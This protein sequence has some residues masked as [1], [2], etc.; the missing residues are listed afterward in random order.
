M[1]RP[2]RAKASERAARSTNTG[3]NQ[4]KKGKKRALEIEA[5]PVDEKPPL[6][7]GLAQPDFTPVPEAV[8]GDDDPAAENSPAPAVL[9]GDDVEEE[10]E[11]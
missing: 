11:A 10:P 8:Q 4:I 7:E 3:D 2:A 5:V 6:G 1:H 9:A